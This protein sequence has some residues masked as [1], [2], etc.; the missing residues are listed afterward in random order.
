VEFV[1]ADGRV[2]C[3]PLVLTPAPPR[4]SLGTLALWLA[5][6]SV[7]L[8]FMPG[9]PWV[10]VKRLR[11]RISWPQ[12]A[13]DVRELVP[14]FTESVARC[15]GDATVAMVQFSGGLDSLA[16]LLHA[17]AICRADGRRLIAAV[18]ELVDGQG[19][20]CS[21]VARRLVDGLG[22]RCE[23]VVFD[24]DPAA[25]RAP[26]WSPAG[27][28]ADAMPR[29]NT[30]IVDHAER[31]GAGVVLNGCGADEV[32]QAPPFLTRALLRAWRLRDTW[33][34]VADETRYGGFQS[35]LAQAA[36]TIG[37]WLPLRESYALYQSFNAFDLT[38]PAPAGVLGER[39]VPYARQWHRSWLAER[40]ELFKRQG[41]D[42][43][44]AAAWESVF[45]GDMLMSIGAVPQRSPFLEPEFASW[46]L[47]IP[48]PDRYSHTSPLPYH[49]YKPL[50]IRLF[51]AEARPSLPVYKQLFRAALPA[52]AAKT[53]AHITERRHKLHCSEYRLVNTS[54]ERVL[55]KDAR[56]LLRVVALEE[57][58]DGALERGAMAADEPEI[59]R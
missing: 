29:L 9:C 37:P 25:F 20:R 43:L 49:R 19:V 5:N 52:H 11:S 21:E 57:W 48:F 31:V 36:S 17:D 58:I 51:P 26:E 1:S 27:P 16:V 35:F 34:Y 53:L 6:P 56:I 4:F 2:H 28:R 54:D 38:D 55:A 41:C 42:W 3:D 12:P 22:L 50:A 44:A 39:Y 32:L 18:I 24:G 40:M 13:S 59:A 33:R 15:L 7:E 46:A 23:L 8:D 30:A 45:S 14:R 10:G 47:G